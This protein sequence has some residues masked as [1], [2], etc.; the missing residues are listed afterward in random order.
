MDLRV[1]NISETLDKEMRKHKE[2]KGSI[3]EMRNTSLDGINSRLKK[4]R[5]EL[6]T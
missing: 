1:D 2:I 4:Q 3:H 6:M 5:N